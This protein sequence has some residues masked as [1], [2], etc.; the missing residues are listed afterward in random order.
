MVNLTPLGLVDDGGVAPDFDQIRELAATDRFLYVVNEAD[1]GGTDDTIRARVSGSL[2]NLTAGTR[3]LLG[4]GATGGLAFLTGATLRG[5]LGTGT[6]DSTTFLRGDGQWAV[7][8]GSGGG[9]ASDLTDLGDVSLSSTDPADLATKFLRHDGSAWTDYVLSHFT[10]GTNLVSDA[11][12]ILS[13]NTNGDPLHGSDVLI[14]AGG[15]GALVDLVGN[16]ETISVDGVNIV[17]TLGPAGTVTSHLAAEQPHARHAHL[18]REVP[19][20][21]GIWKLDLNE[22]ADLGA[23]AT[24]GRYLDDNGTWS[25]PSGSGT[26]E[27][28]QSISVG[29]GTAIG[30]LANQGVSIP[31]RSIKA[32]SRSSLALQFSLDATDS[33]NSINL[34]LDIDGPLLKGSPVAGDKLLIHN[35]ANGALAKIDVGTILGDV[36]G[37]G[38]STADALAFYTGATGKAIGSGNLTWDNGTATLGTISGDL[39][40]SPAGNLLVNGNT[41]FDA[42]IVTDA[43]GSILVR[44]GPNSGAD[45]WT[46]LDPT[47]AAVGQVLTLTDVSGDKVPRWGAVAGTGDV[48]GPASSTQFAMALHAFDSGTLL[49]NDRAGVLT[50]EADVLT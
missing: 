47:A 17:D 38:S 12:P 46:D 25:T 15:T 41:V 19:P 26:G 23:G 44:E 30:G 4:K 36:T 29:S 32:N 3:S 5:A 35:S 7:P 27:V 13:G 10:R 39:N 1:Y 24:G 43:V 40:I 9:G 48:V 16:G 8:P 34:N 20:G 37:P 28:N 49:D 6:L 45:E 21:S 18:T 14:N 2:G 11:I 42:N 33:N 31:I 50:F 22:L